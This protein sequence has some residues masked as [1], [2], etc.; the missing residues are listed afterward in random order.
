[1][2]G[3]FSKLTLE[4]FI[5]FGP[6]SFGLVFFFGLFIYQFFKK[7]KHNL[8]ELFVVGATGSSLPTA[9]LMI[10]GAYDTTV[11]Q[12]ISDSHVYIAFAGASLLYITYA[13]VK[14]KI[15]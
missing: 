3:Y 10:Y 14:E 6:V 1:M 11:I 7:K 2:F 8:G 13:T 9:M 12:K 15:K 4:R 5:T